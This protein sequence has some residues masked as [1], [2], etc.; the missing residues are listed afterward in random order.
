MSIAY[1][2]F[3]FDK[4]DRAMRLIEEPERLFFHLEEIDIENDEYLF[5]GCERNW[6]ARPNYQAKERCSR[7][8][9]SCQAIV[10]SIS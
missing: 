3:V 9:R 5:W 7:K 4:S 6:S 1:P 8:L 2:L 10:R